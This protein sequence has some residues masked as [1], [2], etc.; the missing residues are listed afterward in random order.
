MKLNWYV[1]NMILIHAIVILL[2]LLYQ[3]QSLN[4]LGICFKYSGAKVWN[5]IP[6]FKQCA[7][8]VDRSKTMHKKCYI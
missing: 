8:S 5:K 3:S 6:L 2:M 7:T 4:V 1:I